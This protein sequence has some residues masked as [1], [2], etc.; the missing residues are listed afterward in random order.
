MIFLTV[1]TLLPFD[2]LVRA[3]DVCLDDGLIDEDVFAQIGAGGFKPRNIKYT[4]VFDK[5]T[6]DRYVDKASCL[7]SHAG[8]GSITVALDRKKP[9]LVMPRLECFG[10]HVND[11]Q[12]YTARKF[13][14]MGHILAAY[15]EDEL[16]DKIGELKSFAP[17]QR[18]NQVNAVTNRIAGF[19]GEISS[20]REP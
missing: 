10:E 4:E 3:I 2:R 1:G 15:Q 8:V 11:H 14:Q 12:L 20:S 16:P 7:I 9:L 17:R 19:L 6:F 18:E 5:R 13:E